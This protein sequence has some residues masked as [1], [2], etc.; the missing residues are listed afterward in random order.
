MERLV[1]LKHLRA[2]RMYSNNLCIPGSREFFKRHG[3]DWEDFI[4][5]GIDVEILLGI[6]D[7][8]AH[9]VVRKANELEGWGLDV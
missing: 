7:A 6:D 9:E 4:R 3:L 2:V 1:K 5:N 8:M